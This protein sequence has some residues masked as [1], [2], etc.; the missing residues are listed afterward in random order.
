MMTALA[1]ASIVLGVLVALN[2]Y[3]NWGNVQYLWA[4][5]VILAGIWG[6]V[7]KE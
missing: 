1:I 4:V 2:Q 6:L 7:T 5:L 3:L